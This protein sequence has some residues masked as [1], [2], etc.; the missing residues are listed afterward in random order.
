MR[1][2]LMLSAEAAGINWVEI[3]LTYGALGAIIFLSLIAL[4]IVRKSI[5]KEASLNK[6]KN[7]CNKARAYAEKM[8]AKRSKGE[9]LIASTRLSKLSNMIAEAEWNASCIVEEK[10]DLI[11]EDIVTRLDALACNVSAKAEEAFFTE[12]EYVQSLQDGI[13]G[14]RLIVEEVSAILSQKVSK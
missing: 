10:K 7:K 13:E 14:L 12:E 6:V 3:G 1:V 2:F 4:A 8:L 5:R 11:L 9:L